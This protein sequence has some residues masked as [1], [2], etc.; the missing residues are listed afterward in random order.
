MACGLSCALGQQGFPFVVLVEKLPTL[1]P[2][3]ILKHN[4]ALGRTGSQCSFG[5]FRRQILC[6]A[7]AG[8]LK[9]PQCSSTGQFS[10][11]YPS[12]SP[13]AGAPRKAGIVFPSPLN[14]LLEGLLPGRRSN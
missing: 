1:P 11:D 9:S 12:F 6:L 10:E 3:A 2:T 8:N 7:A 4:P 14:Q 13:L 5:V